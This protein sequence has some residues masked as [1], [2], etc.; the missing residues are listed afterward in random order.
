MTLAEVFSRMAA[1]LAEASF[2]SINEDKQ[3]L[4]SMPRRADAVSTV[5]PHKKLMSRCAG[6][7]SSWGR[8]LHSFRE[9][10]GIKVKMTRIALDCIGGVGAVIQIVLLN[11]LHSWK[12]SAEFSTSESNPGSPSQKEAASFGGKRPPVITGETNVLQNACSAVHTTRM[13]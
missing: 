1:A 8:F 5:S 2:R 9:R 11:A 6:K 3:P 13:V 10:S 4:L 12:T 7:Q